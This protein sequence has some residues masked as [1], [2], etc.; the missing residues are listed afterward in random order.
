MTT[1]AYARPL[2]QSAAITPA[3]AA[4][5]L[6]AKHWDGRLPVVPEQIATAEGLRVERLGLFEDYEFS[7]EFLKSQRLIYVNE[8][9]PM[10]R[11][12]FTLAHELGHYA[13]GHENSPRDTS[14]EFSS[15]TGDPKERA[16]N[17][18]AAELLMP[19]EAVAK[20]VQSGRF[21]SV[22]ELAKAFNVSKVAMTYRINN[23]GLLV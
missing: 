3:A 20:L 13:L 21:G 12:R 19:A 15:R 14:A 7:G 8:R 2:P 23:L 16:A 4:R 22:D 10:V 9:E 11:Q 6:L 18:F 1:E 5:R 17:Q